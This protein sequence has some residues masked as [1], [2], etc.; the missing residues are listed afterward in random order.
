MTAP[1]Q[2]MALIYEARSR[3]L[4]PINLFAPKSRLRA[5]GVGGKGVPFNTL[6]VE[7]PFST[8]RVEIPFNTLR[9][10]VP[11]STLRVEVPFGT[12]RVGERLSSSEARG[13]AG[14]NKPPQSD[15]GGGL[16]SKVVWTGRL[17]GST[18]I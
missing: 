2:S 7:V 13:G 10:E 6:R 4:N 16:F 14:K 8:L 9:V 18:S 12:L 17:P 3:G 11:F 5:A 1:R 15:D